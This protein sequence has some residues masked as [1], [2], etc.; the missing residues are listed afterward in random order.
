M[1]LETLITNVALGQTGELFSVGIQSGRFVAINRSMQ[2]S[3]KWQLDAQGCLMLPGLV[4]PHAHLDKCY[5]PMTSETGGLISAIDNM[6]AIKNSRSL[7][8]VEARARRGLERAISKGVCHMRSHLDLGTETDLAVIERL[9]RLRLDYENRIDLEFTLLCSLDTNE[10]IELAEKAFALGADAIGGAPALTEN[11]KKNIDAALAF[12]EKHGCPLD[13]HI[14]ENEDPESGCLEYLADRILESGFSQRVTAGHC[15]S[16]AFQSDENRARVISKVAE[17]GINIISLPSCNLYLMGRDKTPA[18]RGVTPLNELIRNGVNVSAG[19]DNVQDPFHPWGDYEP[20][21][22]ACT[23]AAVAPFD[24]D[25]AP[26]PDSSQAPQLA[27]DLITKN[28]AKAMGISEYGIKEGMTANF[29]L[30]R[31]K[32]LQQAI[33][34]RSLRTWVFF[35]GKPVVKQTLEQVWFDDRA[36]KNALINPL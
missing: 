8:E 14:D 20:L 36:D 25:N 5:S 17:A 33:T 23:S 9:V 22:T 3:A 35:R 16:L 19:C 18:P 28:A 30:L 12:A 24:S 34:E 4:E 2:V 13:L 29:C 1:L 31:C 11:P 6:R 7:D 27:I 32:T 26:E 10:N 21:G 15:C